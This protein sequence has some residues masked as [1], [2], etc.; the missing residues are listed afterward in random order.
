MT[1]LIKRPSP[2]KLKSM[3]VLANVAPNS[4]RSFPF[5]HL[6]IENAVESEIYEKLTATFPGAE[7]FLG[8]K[9]LESNRYYWL[10]A[11]KI[12]GQE[13]FSRAWSDFVRYHTSRHFF[14]EVLSIFEK[15]I[16]NTLPGLRQGR[17]LREWS[18]GVRH[19]TP[20]KEIS[21]EC[22]L[23]YCS[24][25]QHQSSRSRGP[26]VDREVALFGG[27]LYMRLKEDFSEGG[28]LVIQE[29][30][31]PGMEAEFDARN[32]IN[33]DLVKEFTTIRYSPN[34]LVFFINSPHSIHSVTPR[35][36]TS[37]PRLHVNFAAEVAYP[38]FHLRKPHF[39]NA[40][41]NAWYGNK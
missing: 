2:H 20:R 30:R 40:R 35:S 16:L 23:T 11:R 32:H 39:D 31:T 34:T 25:V 22:Q 27:L 41:T 17:P 3:S 15:D 6:V 33:D 13:P 29:L 24:A 4:V 8:D 9:E 10:E 5:P 36:V 14:H 1:D 37:F 12:L 38:L 19:S 18:T 28:D 26:H 21:L 7:R